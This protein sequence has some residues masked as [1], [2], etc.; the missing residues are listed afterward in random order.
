MSR[1][2]IALALATAFVMP[3]MARAAPPPVE[4]YGKL[5]A[6]DEVHLSPSGERYAEIADD[7]K[8]RGLYVMTTDNKPLDVVRLG[9]VKV[10]D[11]SWAGDDYVLIQT[12]T[13]VGLGPGYLFGKAELASVV[14]L[15]LRSHKSIQVFAY[16]NQT[17]PAVFGSYGVA[18]IKGRWY[19]YFGGLTIGQPSGNNPG[20]QHT[21]VRDSGPNETIIPDLYRVDLETGVPEKAATGD[22]DDE[23]WLI[24][25]D[26]AIAA[27]TEYE[28]N[29]GAWRV[30]TGGFG[31]RV[32]ESG[33]N[34]LGG[35]ELLGLDQMAGAVLVSRD[36]PDG[37][38]VEEVPLAGG[39]AK[40]I[41]P[42]QSQDR[43]I[44]DSAG[45]VWIGI[46]TDGDEGVQSFFDPV[47]EAR[48]R[49]ALKAF[50]GYRAQLTSWS[51]D[52]GKM[53]VFTDGADDS[54]TYWIVDVD[55]KSAK[56]LGSTY[57]TVTPTDVG[58]VRMIDYK[59]AD[60]LALRG[61]LT[62]PPGRA[63][64]G[65]PVVVMPHGGPWERDYPGF[66][67]WAQAFA[68]RGYAVFQPNFRSS[69]GY[70]EA[71][72]KAGYG[73]WGRKMQ[74]DI[75]DGVAE[76]A[77]EGVIDPKRACI[78]GWSYGGYAALA[79]VRSSTGSIG[80]PFPWP[81]CPICQVNSAILKTKPGLRAPRRAIGGCSSARAIYVIFLRPVRQPKPTR[82]SCSFTVT[83]IP[84]CSS[85]RATRWNA[86]SKPLESRWNG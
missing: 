11:V 34:K 8:T 29:T 42:A 37:S 58:P 28:Q 68:S 5:P 43:P 55:K 71:L 70:G 20:G 72:Y 19:G 44:T 10:T 30:M 75:S 62:L 1:W 66:D 86:P 4:D 7:G 78:V 79:G 80:A 56:I 46:F 77:R 2:L 45:H 40:P 15:N 57:P 23:D 73:Q 48:A 52:F 17:D 81:A 84:S 82:L 32:L 27:R 31:G 16:E 39:P 51:D 50:P 74:T 54:G 64:K 36:T 53:I 60:G 33:V 25:A 47:K 24:T 18:Q 63:A 12:S 83:T 35:P 3:S 22:S 26:G 41:E 61:V 6:I 14:V 67:Y 65:L 9:N 38:I 59:A 76:L 69:T 13:T 21:N 85:A 49:G